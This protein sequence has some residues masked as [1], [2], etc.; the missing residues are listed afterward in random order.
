MLLSELIALAQATLAKHGDIEVLD[1]EE[2]VVD[3]M[4]VD[5]ASDAQKEYWGVDAVDAE[6]KYAQITSFY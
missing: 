5:V 3:G 1:G 6:L 4:V 2:Y